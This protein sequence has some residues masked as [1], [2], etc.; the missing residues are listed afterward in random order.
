MVDNQLIAFGLA[1][2]A[3]CVTPGPAIVYIT[4]RSVDQGTWAGVLSALALALGA[5][6]QSGCAIAGMSAAS[7]YWPMVLTLLKYA[8]ASYLVFM[9][10]QRL[11]ARNVEGAPPAG[12]SSSPRRV[13]ADGVLVNLSNPTSAMFL[14]AFLPQ[15]APESAP[16]A[17]M[18]VLGALFVLIGILVGVGYAVLAGTIGGW[19]R[20]SAAAGSGRRYVVAITYIAIGIAALLA[21]IG[22]E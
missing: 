3:L 16:V 6:I 14:I 4:A 10:L 11:L 17:R 15:F 21:R 18:I 13:V 5:M 8:G 7:A 22:V 1:T 9:G 19:V 20:R 2:F 12:A